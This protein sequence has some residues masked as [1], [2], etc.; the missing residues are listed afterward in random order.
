MIGCRVPDHEKTVVEDFYKIIIMMSEILLQED[1]HRGVVVVVDLNI[2]TLQNLMLSTL[3]VIK[4]FMLY[5]N[6]CF[7][8]RIKGIY[9]LNAPSYFDLLGNIIKTTLSVKLQQRVGPHPCI[10]TVTD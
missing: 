1:F 4:K 9:F 10:H 2:F 7:P 8:S 6:K 3:P 5:A